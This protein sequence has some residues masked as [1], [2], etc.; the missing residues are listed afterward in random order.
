M[1]IPSAAQLNLYKYLLAPVLL[2]QGLYVR[3]TIVELPEP[4]GARLGNT[5]QGSPL[6]LLIL[7]DSAAAGVGVQQQGDALSG[8][9]PALLASHY[10]VDWQLQAAS[11]KT[12]WD[13]LPLIDQCTFE[14][15]DV[16]L[17]SAG[18]N[19]VT[20]GHSTA[21]YLRG[22]QAL[23]DAARLRWP[24]CHLLYSAVPPM[25]QFHALPNPLRWYVGQHARQL[26]SALHQWCA[27]HA[28]GYLPF[29]YNLHP[30]L[31]AADGFHP[32]GALY[33]LW[34]ERAGQWIAHHRP[35]KGHSVRPNGDTRW[36]QSGP[37]GPGL[38]CA[39]S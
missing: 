37:D 24:D 39:N 4:D 11:S 31:I 22:C 28:Y 19:D 18:V 21:H 13:M 6:S 15:C 5:G 1:Q 25:G 26:D 7:G 33:A 9:L 17:I 29:D 12:S 20:R 16:V 34:A 36:L 35:P 3:R 32:S 14:Q 2:A 38:D 27:Q 10:Q 8:H 30:D 23:A